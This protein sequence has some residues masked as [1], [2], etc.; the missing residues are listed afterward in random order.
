[1]R[2]DSTSAQGGKLQPGAF[3][4]ILCLQELEHKSS[5]VAG[6]Q[7]RDEPLMLLVTRVA[8]GVS[9]G[10]VE[11]RVTGVEC[12][13]L[14]GRRLLGRRRGARIRRPG[15]DTVT[16]DEFGTEDPGFDVGRR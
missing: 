4:Q 2:D 9:R 5:P 12:Q 15:N 6:E 14:T 13:L 10:L 3:P 7:C 1:M 8:H 16:L 11:G